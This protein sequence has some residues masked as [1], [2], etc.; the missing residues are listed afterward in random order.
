MKAYLRLI[1]WPNVLMIGAIQ[2]V[3]RYFLVFDYITTNESLFNELQFALLVFASM[4][5]ASGGYA[6]NDYFDVKTDMI[7]KGKELIVSTL[8]KRT[9]VLRFHIFSAIIAS[10]ICF[11]VGWQLHLLMWSLLGPFAI[12]LLYL[13]SLYFKRT[14]FWGNALISLLIAFL[15]F[16]LAFLDINLN[17]LP[18]RAL[19]I[20]ILTGGFAFTTNL[21]REII[22]DIEDR[23]G[24][25]LIGCKTIPIVLGV[26]KTKKLV[27]GLI[28][29]CQAAILVVGFYFKPDIIGLLYAFILLVAPLSWCIYL[30]KFSKSNQQFHTAS[31]W[32]KVIML[33]GMLTILLI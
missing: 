23:K 27:I 24:D 8:I 15:V 30:V 13:Y 1:R 12:L 18:I 21:I 2:Y 16:A 9:H 28:L 31:S 6:I 7:N 4:L 11:I 26:D 5:I 32:M 25:K 22:K 10:L 14:F 17:K 19:N 20:L 3:W 29:F 33:I